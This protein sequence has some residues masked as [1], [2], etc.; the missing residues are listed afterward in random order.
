MLIEADSLDVV[1]QISLT[2]DLKVSP[3]VMVIAVN[4]EDLLASDA[5]DTR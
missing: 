5:Q 1:S 2:G 4:V 3:S